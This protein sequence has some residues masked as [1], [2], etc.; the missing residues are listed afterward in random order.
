MSDLD[1]LIAAGNRSV[2]LGFMLKH[3]QGVYSAT[4]SLLSPD[5]DKTRDAYR[6]A[7]TEYDLAA[8][9]WR[10]LVAEIKRE[11]E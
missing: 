3:A 9:A 7:L 8:E 6:A 2:N 10:A 5:I 4:V 1:R 11:R